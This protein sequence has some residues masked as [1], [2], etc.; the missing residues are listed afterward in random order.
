MVPYL[1]LIA[2]MLQNS[3]VPACVENLSDNQPAVTHL[4]A[5]YLHGLIRPLPSYF[6]FFSLPL[7]CC[8]HLESWDSCHKL[9]YSCPNWRSFR[10][11]TKWSL[12]VRARDSFKSVLSQHCCNFP[13]KVLVSSEP[14]AALGLIYSKVTILYQ[15]RLVIS[16]YVTFRSTKI[17]VVEKP[18]PR[19]SSG[20]IHLWRTWHTLVIF[21]FT[22]AGTS[23]QPSHVNECK[24]P[25]IF[26]IEHYF[27][28][29]NK[30][31]L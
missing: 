26:L 18:E 20:V 2:P 3:E 27:V 22:S 30:R 17:W 23:L 6:F 14:V 21:V 19:V 31:H 4:T 25:N 13:S 7:L 10:S 8:N 15:G 11:C 16:F 5:E 12:A 28:S 1:D 24:H 9:S 29:W